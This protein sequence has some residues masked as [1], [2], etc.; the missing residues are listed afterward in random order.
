[1]FKGPCL[2]A[3]FPGDDRVEKQREEARKQL[4]IQANRR[5]RLVRPNQLVPYTFDKGE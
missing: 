4:V 5:R 1:M 2:I 3:R